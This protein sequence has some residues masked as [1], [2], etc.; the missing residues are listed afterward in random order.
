MFFENAAGTSA[1]QYDQPNNAEQQASRKNNCILPAQALT[2]QT[3]RRVGFAL[4]VQGKWEE[5]GVGCR[6]LTLGGCV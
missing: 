4:C 5:V 1:H 3:V 6:W 2:Q